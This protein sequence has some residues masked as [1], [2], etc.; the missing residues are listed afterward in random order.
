M[1][2]NERTILYTIAAV[3][4]LNI[5]LNIQS[6]VNINA[7]KEVHRLQDEIHARTTRTL[8]EHNESIDNIKE[9]I[10]DTNN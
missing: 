6:R 5:I 7:F 1:N 2:I 8:K 9:F 3:S 10:E 4:F